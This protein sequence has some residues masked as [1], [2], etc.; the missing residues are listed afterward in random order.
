MSRLVCALAA[1]LLLAGFSPE[2]S[3]KVPPKD[4]VSILD[5]PLPPHVAVNP[6]GGALL[7]V[8]FEPNPPL[9][10]L[11]APILRLAGVR[12]D[13][14]ISALQRTLRYTGISV[15]P[16]GGAPPR[17]VALPVG[18]RI[19]FPAWSHDGRRFA[20]T[21][22]LADGVELWVGDAASATA[23]PVGNL[24]V[25]DVLG[26][27]FRWVGEGQRLIVRTVPPS[28]DAPPRPPRIPSG[29]AVDETAGKQSQLP[30]YQDL[31]K[32]QFDELLFE[33]YGRSQLMLMDAATSKLSP[34][35]TP[36]L[37]LDAT[38]SPD[39]R[40]VLVTRL[41]R[42]FSHR[43]LYSNF[44]RSIEVWDMTGA[45]VATV[46]DLPV[47][48]EIPRHGV[49]TGPRNVAW[50]P[51]LP[52]TLV[53]REALD[54]G[55]PVRKV[56]RRDRLMAL[57]APFKGTPRELLQAKGRI[58]GLDW[59]SRPNALLMTE[60]D[61]DRRW[62]TTTLL[63]LANPAAGKV[64]FDRSVNDA[65][66]DPGNPVHEVRANGDR[67][68][69]QD[70]NAIYLSG[71]GASEAGERPFLDALDLDSLGKTRLQQSEEGVYER[72]VSFQKKDS[73]A[74]ILTRRESRAEPPNLHLVDL[75][76]GARRQFT[77][78]RDPAP[79]LQRVR[80]ELIRYT[81]ADGVP[82]SGMLYLPPGYAAG[83]RLPVLVWAYPREYSD[84]DT[85]GQTRGSPNRFAIPSGDSPVLLALRGYAV[86]MNATMPIVGNPETMNNT[87]IEQIAA[88]AKA[89]VDKLD[90]MGVADRAR[91]VVGGHSYGAFMTANL[92]AHTDLFVAGIARSGAYNRSLTPFGFQNERRSYWEAPELYQKISPF[93]H[94]NRINEP[95]L[96]VHGEADN[97]T[98]TYPIQS[99]RLF[100]AIRGNG[101]TAR[102]V[103]LP[104]ES[105]GYRARESV[106][107]VLAEMIEWADRWT[108]LPVARAGSR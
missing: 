84:A 68:V 97:N 47:T 52:A 74:Q 98:G 49:S 24:R 2:T 73:R 23:R 6:R 26:P 80:R 94:A 9:A 64:V 41:R 102:L 95:L 91:I 22:D 104:H 87:Y 32:T 19:G 28:R 11:A 12:I 13:P 40:H 54:G 106:L 34:L 48:D 14:A 20:F 8:E 88:N 90:E 21:R 30:T 50:Q 83:T 4:I 107:H 82:L 57:D 53:W 16:L 46:A 56:P 45:R 101:G 3:Y 86:L 61:R 99:E 5:A 29:P 75:A 62:T 15:Q 66:N 51:L 38:L 1:V 108:K 65:Y 71:S 96:L 85:A 39:G 27:P 31:L 77:D 69:L 58:N 67:V 42:P 33:H 89:A 81:R 37:L 63:D 70:G 43:V 17:R 76:N 18:A 35:G 105:H 25:T 10:L 55:D 44:T 72:F 103:M 7:L 78:Y 93:T 100:E 59:M 60:F 36:G 79:Q 92:L